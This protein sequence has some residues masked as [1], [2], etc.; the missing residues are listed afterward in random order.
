MLRVCY[1]ILLAG[2]ALY[3]WPTVVRHHAAFAMSGCIRASLLAG[4]GLTAVL[5]FRYPV[6]MVPLLMFELTWKAIYPGVGAA[7]VPG[8]PD[9]AEDHGRC[10]G[11]AVGADSDSTDPRGNTCSRRK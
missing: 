2:L 10:A 7:A 6:K 11:C 8:A 4:L 1:F 9:D 5:G 3:V